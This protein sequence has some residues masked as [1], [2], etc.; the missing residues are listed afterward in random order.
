MLGL[1]PHRPT[2]CRAEGGVFF[3]LGRFNIIKYSW[4]LTWKLNIFIGEKEKHGRKAPSFGF[5]VSFFW[6]VGKGNIYIYIIMYVYI[7]IYIYI[8]VFQSIIFGIYVKIWRCNHLNLIFFDMEPGFVD[9]RCC[10]LPCHFRVRKCK[11][12]YAP[13]SKRWF[14][15]PE[16]LGAWKLILKSYCINMY[17]IYTYICF[18]HRYIC[19]HPQIWGLVPT[20]YDAPTLFKKPLV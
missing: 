1:G 19:L 11:T 18:T 4:K 20:W 7:I 10:R 2:D 13:T 12:F 14:F 5:H 16:V 6:G 8:H 17:C 3:G 9:S 15:S